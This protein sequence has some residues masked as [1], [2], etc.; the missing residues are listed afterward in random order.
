M[1]GQKICFFTRINRWSGQENHCCKIRK[2]MLKNDVKIHSGSKL[3]VLYMI[4]KP[5]DLNCLKLS[6][7]S[8]VLF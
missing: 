7:H 8:S 3:I 4:Y 6:L 2:C 5:L 1:R